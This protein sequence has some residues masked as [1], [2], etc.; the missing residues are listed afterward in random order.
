VRRHDDAAGQASYKPRGRKPRHARW[1]SGEAKP[2]WGFDDS[3]SGRMGEWLVRVECAIV[4]MLDGDGAR[5]DSG[6]T[7]C[8]RSNASAA[9]GKAVRFR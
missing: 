1:R 4:R 6:M 9:K 5:L 7:Q 3:Q 8:A 2:L